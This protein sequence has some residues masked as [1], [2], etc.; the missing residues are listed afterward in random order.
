M[1]L[2]TGVSFEKAIGYYQQGKE[3]LVLD[4]ASKS[5]TGSGYDTFSFEE[6][7]GNLDFLVDVPAVLDPEFEQAVREMVES[8]KR[9]TAESE[10]EEFDPE[11]E[12]KSSP[13]TKRWKIKRG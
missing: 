6:L 8:G 7:F 5:V 11:D 13:P 10:T 4:R 1:C 9:E 3:V 12:E 2:F